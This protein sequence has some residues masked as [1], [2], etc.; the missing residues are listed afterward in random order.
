MISPSFHRQFYK[1]HPYFYITDTRIMVVCNYQQGPVKG[2]T[3]FN[4]FPL[5][6]ELN[7]PH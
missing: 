4:S 3:S 2:C 6:F 5:N 1:L 7:E